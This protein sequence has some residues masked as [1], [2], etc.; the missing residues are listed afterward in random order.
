MS[1]ER[2][3]SIMRFFNFGENPLFENDWLSKL[4]MILDHLNKVIKTWK[5]FSIDKSMMLW[6]GC[7]VFRQYIKSKH[8]KYGIK[9]YKLYT[10]DGLISTIEAYCGQGF[11]G[12]HNLGQTV[13]MVL[14]LMNP[15]LLH[16]YYF[17][18]ISF[19]KKRM[20]HSA[21]LENTERENLKKVG[22]FRGQKKMLSFVNGKTRLMFSQFWMHIHHKLLPL[23]IALEKKKTKAQRGEGLQRFNLWNW[24]QWPGVTLPLKGK[25]NFDVVQKSS[26][27]HPWDL[28]YQCILPLP[29]FNWRKRKNGS[30]TPIVVILIE[31]INLPLDVFYAHKNPA[32]FIFCSLVYFLLACL[33]FVLFVCSESFRKKN[34][35]VWNCPNRLN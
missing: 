7:L 11:N 29:K 32:F 21:N 10:N 19:E 34:K 24:W 18:R 12:E 27:T 33:L 25:K 17:K 6:R 35:D 14:K 16:Y 5:F 15:F 20:S 31:A 3:Q 8:Y 22:W 30:M 4:R 13:A 9:F 26:S 23:L 1:R 2:F 28:R